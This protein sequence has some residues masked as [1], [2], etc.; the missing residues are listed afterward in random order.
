MLWPMG[1]MQPEQSPL[2]LSLEAVSESSVVGLR[3][4]KEKLTE[5]RLTSSW[6]L[7]LTS[8][9]TAPLAAH[10]QDRVQRFAVDQL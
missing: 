4:L 9:S 3:P 8:V 2:D 10:N 6:S 1:N 7:F 5:V